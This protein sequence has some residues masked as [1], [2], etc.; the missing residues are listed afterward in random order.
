MDSQRLFLFFIFLYNFCMTMRQT[1]KITVSTLPRCCLPMMLNT[2]CCSFY[3][4]ELANLSFIPWLSSF[5]FWLLCIIHL[6]QSYCSERA[7]HRTNNLHTRM[8][9]SQTFIRKR[10]CHLLCRRK[11]SF[12][13][14]NLSGSG[15]TLQSCLDYHC[16]LAG[17]RDTESGLL[18]ILSRA[19]RDV[20]QK[21]WAVAVLSPVH[22]WLW[23][24]TGGRGMNGLI[25][26]ITTSLFTSSRC[27]VHSA[28]NR[29]TQKFN[30]FCKLCHRSLQN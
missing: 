7:S 12:Q 26:S 19:I 13:C 18:D 8:V 17:D 20:Y 3:Q 14:V 22:P 29:L 28:K 9:M 11:Q 6:T 4:L 1:G 27:I 16:M 10:R 5:S 30:L 25:I 24:V 21:S 15:L 2:S 23:S